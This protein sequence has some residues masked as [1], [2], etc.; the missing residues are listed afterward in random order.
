MRP[1][2]C[3]CLTTGLLA[4]EPPLPGRDPAFL[5]RIL[6]D[7]QG[8]TQPWKTFKVPEDSGSAIVE[9]VGEYTPAE[10]RQVAFQEFLVW[11]REDLRRFWRDQG[12][13]GALAREAWS[14]L[15]VNQSS[16]PS[17]PQNGPQVR[18]VF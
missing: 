2:L 7:T 5:G 18:I 6:A 16:G 4:G 14:A 8:G 3:L 10:L 1:L 12:F 15:P 13:P 17:A 9:V 11:F